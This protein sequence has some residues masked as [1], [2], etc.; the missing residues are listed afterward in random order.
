MNNHH[1]QLVAPPM[2]VAMDPPG[3]AALY[4]DQKFQNVAAPMDG[5][6]PN[7]YSQGQSHHQSADPA[8]QLNGGVGQQPGMVY[9]VPPPSPFFYYAVAAPTDMVHG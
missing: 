7:A 9:F 8:W 4:Y 1:H 3:S 6:F 2:Q 5:Q